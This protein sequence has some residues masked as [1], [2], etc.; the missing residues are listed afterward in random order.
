MANYVVAIP[1]AYNT[2]TTISGTQQLGDL[3]ISTGNTIGGSVDWWDGPNMSLG[4]IICRPKP[5]GDQPNPLNVPAYIAFWRSDQLSDN[6]F[7]DLGNL[8]QSSQVFI[9]ASQVATWALNQQYWSNWD[10]PIDKII[11]SG[12]S[13]NP[14]WVISQSSGEVSFINTNDILELYIASSSSIILNSYQY[15]ISYPSQPYYSLRIT[16]EMDNVAAIRELII[17]DNISTLTYNLT[18]QGITTEDFVI[19]TLSGYL[20]IT[21]YIANS[22]VD[23]NGYLKIY[24][25][26]L[27]QANNV[28]TPY[29][30]PNWNDMT[31]SS[32][33]YPFTTQQIL[34]INPSI[35]I[36]S[37]YDLTYASL[38]YKITSAEITDFD[39]GKDPVTDQGFTYFEPGITVITVSNGEWLS[40]SLFNSGDAGSTTATLRNVSDSEIDLDTFT[41]T[42]A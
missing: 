16:Y 27:Y 38:A 8:L 39:T 17:S 20:S 33:V 12:N 6:S 34:G 13:Y 18:N 22:N 11:Y 31:I 14:L 30:Y 23:G 29:P 2:G 7:I 35:D 41:I 37:L 5:A 25:I 26:S 1:F 21:F 28:V 15:Q 10:S 3:A 36:T 42:N 4:Y 40:L 9:R 19:D 32:G 24:G